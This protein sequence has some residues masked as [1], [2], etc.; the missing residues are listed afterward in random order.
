MARIPLFPRLQPAGVDHILEQTEGD[1]PPQPRDS[2][3][4][5]AD[6]EMISF[7]ASG[8]SRDLNFVD[9][10]AEGIR[11]CAERHGFPESASQAKRANFDQD[12]A[13]L[14]GMQWRLQTGEGLRND[15]WAFLTTVMVPDVVAWRFPDQASERFH[16]G[17]RN[18]FQRLWIRGYALDRGEG[19]Q[20]R[21][22]YLRELTEDSMV[23]IFE[24]GSLSSEPQLAQAI[25]ASWFE[26]AEVVGR[27]AMEEVMRSAIK[28]IRLRNEIVDLGAV[29]TR[30]CCRQV[31]ELFREAVEI[32]QRGSEK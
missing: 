19:H 24:R 8:G 21:W 11:G 26:T 17:V 27:S 16:G 1:R 31:D 7:A 5:L 25:A 28:L 20:S 9:S 29:G 2:S 15:V 23:Q 10:L 30:E 12:V 14:L 3:Q 13:I 32:Y 6:I 18:A 22:L 4:A